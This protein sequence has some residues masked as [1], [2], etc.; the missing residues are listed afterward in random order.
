[1]YTERSGV[2]AQLVKFLLNTHKAWRVSV[3]SRTL[4]EICNCYCPTRDGTGGNRSSEDKRRKKRSSLDTR[5]P[6]TEGKAVE[7]PSAH[8]QLEGLLFMLEGEFLCGQSGSVSMSQC[9][10]IVGVGAYCG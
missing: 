10:G 7:S 1:M 3:F 4:S 6:S 5:D 8:N 9:P 2:M